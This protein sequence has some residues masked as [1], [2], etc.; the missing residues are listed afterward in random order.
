VSRGTG[1]SLT[2]KPPETRDIYVGAFRRFDN[3]IA[4]HDMALASFLNRRRPSRHGRG[5][6]HE[7]RNRYPLSILYLYRTAA[8][9][10]DAPRPTTEIGSPGERSPL[11]RARDP[12]RDLELCCCDRLLPCE[13][14]VA[15]IVIRPRIC[16]RHVDEQRRDGSIR[17]G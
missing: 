8:C 15:R 5:L 1:H 3:K 10:T 11:S 9:E 14:C 12:K 4:D 6:I 7:P 2:M 17:R 13:S 16:R